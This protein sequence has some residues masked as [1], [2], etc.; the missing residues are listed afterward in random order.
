MATCD[1]IALTDVQDNFL[2]KVH[3]AYWA[4]RASLPELRRLLWMN[5][6]WQDTVITWLSPDHFALIVN[7]ERSPEDYWQEMTGFSADARYDRS[8][9]KGAFFDGALPV[10]RERVR[11]LVVEPVT[12]EAYDFDGIPDD[13]LYDEGVALG[14]QWA[15]S[16]ATPSEEEGVR[17]YDY[18]I[19][20]AFT[21]H[22]IGPELIIRSFLFMIRP[23]DLSTPYREAW[24][25]LVGENVSDPWNL[26]F[27]VGFMHGAFDAFVPAKLRRTKHR[28][29]QW[30]PH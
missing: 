14:Y 4:Q 11:D 18:F 28:V 19:A 22:P 10:A 30:P 17:E 21:D 29:S 1:D 16:Q 25:R 8:D 24:L 2:A 6:V 12:I 23:D 27:A 26:D 3:G 9:I 5:V 7:P 13:S 15:T 20:G